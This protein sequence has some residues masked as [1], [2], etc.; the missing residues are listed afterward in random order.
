MDFR[1]NKPSGIS[2]FGAMT[3]RNRPNERGTALQAVR[4][5]SSWTT[6]WCPPR[7]LERPSAAAARSAATVSTKA[8]VDSLVYILRSGALNAELKPDPVSE[9]TVGA[10]LGQDTIRRGLWAVGLGVAAVLAFMVGYY[11]FAGVVACV[12]LFVNLLLTVGFMV[13]VNAAFTL[14]GLAG[15]VLMLGMAVDANV[16]IYERIR[17]ERERGANLAT[18]IRLGYDRAFADH[19]RHAPDQHLHLA[20]C[21]TPSATTT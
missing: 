12:A 15:I 7:R 16:L 10:T 8:G 17:E 3:E 5:P 6:G 11:R 18:S 19:H 4:W 9:N 20:S 2:R 21:C 13:A 14:P 1:F